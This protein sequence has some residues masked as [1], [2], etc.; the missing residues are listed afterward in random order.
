MTLRRA[1]SGEK[2]TMTGGGVVVATFGS[3]ALKFEFLQSAQAAPGN[4][5]RPPLAR[6]GGMVGPKAAA[7]S[8][9]L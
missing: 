8:C 4:E 9:W 2:E 1:W 7:G 3:G 6:S 5:R